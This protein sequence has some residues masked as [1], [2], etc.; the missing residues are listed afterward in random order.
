MLSRKNT[1]EYA[2]KM[3]RYHFSFA[4]RKLSIGVA[5]VLLGFGFGLGLCASQGTV[6]YADTTPA[7]AVATT[8]QTTS[9]GSSAS[10]TATSSATSN[11][12]ANTNQGPQVNSISWNNSSPSAYNKGTGVDITITNQRSSTKEISGGGTTEFSFDFSVPNSVRS[13]DYTTISLPDELDFI[14]DQSFNVYASDG[15][16]TVASA[17]ISKEKIRWS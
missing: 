14:R 4:I 17:I 16:T 15:T 13:G 7:T 5:S 11:G 12:G 2:K 3:E 1:Q 6:A 8:A 10:A 9:A